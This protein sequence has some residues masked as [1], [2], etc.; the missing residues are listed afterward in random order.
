MFLLEMI[1]EL[2]TLLGGP[3]IK[4]ELGRCVIQTTIAKTRVGGGELCSMFVCHNGVT[5]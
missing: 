4:R 1:L 5:I 3:S 2:I